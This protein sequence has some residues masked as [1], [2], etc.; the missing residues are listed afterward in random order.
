ML[1]FSTVH[2]SLLERI[3]SSQC[4]DLK[5]QEIIRDIELGQHNFPAYSWKHNLLWWHDKI[6]IPDDLDLQ[7]T[8]LH[9]FHS[10]LL[11]GHAGQFRT[12]ARLAA[13]F[14]WPGMRRAVKTYIKFCDIC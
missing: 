3:Q 10:S 9:E 7:S 11:G 12:L 6:A 8:L 4:K 14:F 5:F 1:A 2:T 13:Q